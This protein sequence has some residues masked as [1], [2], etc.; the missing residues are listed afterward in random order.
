MKHYRKN[1]NYLKK[2]PKGKVVICPSRP[3]FEMPDNKYYGER[4]LLE[5]GAWG[6]VKIEKNPE[7][8]ALYLSSP[9][10]AVRY[11]AVIDEI[12]S[13]EGDLRVENYQEYEIY[14]PGKMVIHLEEPLIELNDE[15]P[16]EGG[17][18][19]NIRYTTLDKFI[20]AETTKDLW[21]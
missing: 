15:I 5:Y 1:R 11:F 18:I 10:K 3:G 17:I 20:E 19:P 9:V 2:Y 6:F 16:F 4:F 13:P 8:F 21:S 14:S 7:Y 12:I